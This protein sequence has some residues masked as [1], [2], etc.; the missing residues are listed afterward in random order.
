MNLVLKALQ[1]AM[2]KHEGQTRRGSGDAYVSHPLAVSYLVAGYKISKKIDEILAASLLHDT[3]EDTETTF[4]EIATEFT[5]LVAGLVM[6]LTN[7]ESQIAKLG[8][9]EYQK[10]KLCGIS[11]Y[12]LVIKLADRLHNVSDNPTKKMLVDTLELV[13]YVSESRKLSKTQKRMIDDIVGVCNA[14][15]DVY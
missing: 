12:G 11:S 1:F 15:L 2:V 6:E 4:L 5:P 9:L 3:I 14:K 10:K 13:A 7:D 8:K